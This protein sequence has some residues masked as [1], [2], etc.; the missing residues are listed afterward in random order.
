MRAFGGHQAAVAAARSDFSTLA[1]AILA[2][3]GVEAPA[4]DQEGAPR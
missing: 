2:R 3:L 4:L 1:D